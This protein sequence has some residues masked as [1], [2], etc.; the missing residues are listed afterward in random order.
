VPQPIFILGFPRSGTT[1]TEQVLA[2]HSHIRPGGELPFVAAFSSLIARLTG[3]PFPAAV[4]QVAARAD[5]A[6]QLR[7]A[8]LA[9]AGAYGLL[10]NG[11]A[12]FTDKMPLNEVYLPLI[13]L[14]FPQARL[15]AVSR[16]P[17]DVMVSAM[18]HD[19]THGFHCTYRLD[20]AARHFAAM[21]DLTEQFRTAGIIPY[22][23]R[24]ESFVAD[25]KSET[26]RLMAFVGLAPEPA[27]IAFHQSRRH[28]PTPSYAQV[29]E[30]LHDRAVGRWRHYAAQLAPV[31]DM[32]APAIGR[33]SY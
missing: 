4:G 1:M 30:P 31:A 17:R 15:I 28:A 16:D 29:R 13:R 22:A 26:A 24:Y 27:Q 33:G 2:S 3:L 21:S 14:A 12:F 5:F 6:V 10:E 25:Q 8:Y 32:L 20:D 11:A 9:Q 19:M 23:F 7:D 18:Q